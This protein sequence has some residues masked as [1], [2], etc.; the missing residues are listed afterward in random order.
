MTETPAVTTVRRTIR[1]DHLA[2]VEG[3]GM[4][5]VAMRNGRVTQSEFRL[6]EAPRFFEALLRG[7]RFSDA[8]DITARICGI[9]PVAYQMSACQAMEAALGVTLDEPLK[10]LRRLLYCGEWIESHALHVYL[11][12]APDF[13]GYEDAIAL[14]RDH[15][16]LVKRGLALKKAGNAIVATLGGRE[17]HPINVRVG[18]FHRLPRPGELEGLREPLEQALEIAGE[19]VRLV[20]GFDFPSLE[21]DYELLALRD[22]ERYAMYEG[23][24][25]SSRG[26][27]CPVRDFEQHVHEVQVPHSTAMQGRIAGRGAYHTGPLAR[28]VLNGGQ[29]HPLARAALADAGVDASCRNPFKSIIARSVEILHACEEALRILGSYRAPG[30]A[31]MDVRGGRGEG[32]G[33]SEAPRGVLYHRYALDD[34]GDI[35]AANIVPPTAQNQRI[36]EE[37]LCRLVEQEPGLEQ[38]ALTWRCEQLV[39][40]YD[41]CISCATHFLRVERVPS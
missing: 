6:F 20:A 3:H 21:T 31:A 40:C 30:R 17:I 7:R 18:G 25:A 35:E 39:R 32:W 37:D 26:L 4:F 13:L 1:V 5:R 19:T 33:A 38:D 11:L 2:R 36:I 41:P 10:E 16:E 8:P 22:P 9:C 27:D 15:P 28:V 24:L 29:L 14:S 23:R 12:H 34:A